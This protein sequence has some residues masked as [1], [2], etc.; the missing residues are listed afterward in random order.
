VHVDLPVEVAVD[1][2]VAGRELDGALLAR[3]LVA[4]G[5]LVDVSMRPA[6]RQAMRRSSPAKAASAEITRTSSVR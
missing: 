5:D 6:A 2:S 3:D 4:V 1:A